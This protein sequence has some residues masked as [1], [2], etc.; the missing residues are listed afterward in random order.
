MQQTAP[1]RNGQNGFSRE[2][3]HKRPSPSGDTVLLSL[4]IL[5]LLF[6]CPLKLIDH[7]LSTCSSLD[8]FRQRSLDRCQVFSAKMEHICTFFWIFLVCKV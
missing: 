5:F 2:L 4:S 3:L 6:L 8:N 1:S 7:A